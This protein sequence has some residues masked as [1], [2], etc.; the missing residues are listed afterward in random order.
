MCTRAVFLNRQSSFVAVIIVDEA[1]LAQAIYNAVDHSILLPLA[2]SL[3]P[4]LGSR[5]ARVNTATLSLLSP[6]PPGIF[7]TL[8]SLI[9]FP[10]SPSP[11]LSRWKTHAGNCSCVFLLLRSSSFRS[12]GILNIVSWKRYALDR[13]SNSRI[14]I[15]PSSLPL[16]PPGLSSNFSKKKSVSF[17]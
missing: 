5:Y 12:W 14:M 3:P 6:H 10:A 8:P 13:P 1:T 4:F 9:Y 11:F 15:F 7:V 2:F 17:F 16:Q